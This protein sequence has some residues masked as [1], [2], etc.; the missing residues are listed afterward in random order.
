MSVNIWNLLTH[1]IKVERLVTLPI[2]ACLFNSANS[3]AVGFVT[4][5]S[6]I[7]SIQQIWLHF[8]TIVDVKFLQL[9]IP[10]ILIGR[11]FLGNLE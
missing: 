9:L 1:L 3:S 11:V 2:T 6:G 5:V 4:N 10:L 8:D 7:D